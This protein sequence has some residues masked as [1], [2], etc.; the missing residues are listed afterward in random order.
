MQLHVAAGKGREGLREERRAVK[1][2]L[3]RRLRACML[4]FPSHNRACGCREARDARTWSD[5]PRVSGHHA[6]RCMHA[7]TRSIAPETSSKASSAE[8]GSRKTVKV[9]NSEV[10]VTGHAVGRR[11]YFE[12][13]A[14][15]PL[16]QQHS[17]WR[18]HGA[19]SCGGRWVGSSHEADGRRRRAGDSRTVTRE[20][21]KL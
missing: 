15:Q 3:N 20:G 10:S 19:G 4:Q 13:E 11:A 5:L 17:T 21:G 7:A 1:L 16:L 9:S 12:R 6:R 14:A 8:A 2:Q 18:R